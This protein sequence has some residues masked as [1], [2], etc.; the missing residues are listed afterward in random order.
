[1]YNQPWMGYSRSGNGGGARLVV[2]RVDCHQLALLNSKTTS[3]P[4]SLYTPP[5]HNASAKVTSSFIVSCGVLSILPPLHLCNL[6][7][8]TPA[9]PAH[10]PYL[11]SLDFGHALSSNQVMYDY[12][13][14]HAHPTLLRVI[15][16]SS[17][18]ITLSNIALSPFCQRFPRACHPLNIF[19]ITMAICLACD[20]C[21]NRV[22]NDCPLYR[23]ANF[24]QPSFLPFGTDHPSTG[25]LAPLHSPSSPTKSPQY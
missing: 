1:M 21:T 8:V 3:A 19:L 2:E 16:H 25:R 13:T 17:Q 24:R 6:H 9:W 12:H 4:I 5:A 15:C 14:V 23:N 18:V 11:P 22:G 7:P 10:L 20:S